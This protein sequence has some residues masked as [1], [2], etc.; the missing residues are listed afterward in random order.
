MDAKTLFWREGKGGKKH[1]IEQLE[2]VWQEGEGGKK[3]HTKTERIIDTHYPCNFSQE[4]RTDVP[5]EICFT[6]QS[7]TCIHD[8]HINNI[9]F[10]MYVF[11]TYI[12]YELYIYIKS[13][14]KE[15]ALLVL[16]VTIL[17][18]MY[19]K[20]MA[21]SIYVSQPQVAPQ[22]VSVASNV[23]EHTLRAEERRLQMAKIA[24]DRQKK[25]RQGRTIKCEEKLAYQRAK[26]DLIGKIYAIYS[27]RGE[28]APFGL[29]GADLDSLKKHYDRLSS[30]WVM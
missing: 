24:E 2:F 11:V 21:T 19:I 29:G 13:I 1:L 14:I 30:Q 23:P 8:L 4:N 27:I 6:P 3:H 18:F 25:W 26:D 9:W 16:A 22:R 12:M 5:Q 15:I 20:Y 7:T 28:D 17:Y 10:L